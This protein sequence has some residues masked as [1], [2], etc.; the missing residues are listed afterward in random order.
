M[1]AHHSKQELICQTN[2]LPKCDENCRKS[3]SKQN[4]KKKMSSE[5]HFLFNKNFFTYEVKRWSL[6][7]KAT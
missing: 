5:G 3:M 6:L 7:G 2:V 4:L 1:R